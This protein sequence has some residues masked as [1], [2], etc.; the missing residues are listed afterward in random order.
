MRIRCITLIAILVFICSGTAF[1]ANVYVDGAKLD[2]RTSSENNTTL[3][4]LRS[5][6][7][8]LGAEV[9]WN[10][11]EQ[12]VTAVKGQTSVKLKIGVQTAFVNGNPV[13]LQVPGKVINGNT[14]VPLR[15]VSEALGSKVGWDGITGTITIT[16]NGNTQIDSTKPGASVKV[17]RVVDG[18]TIEVDLNGKVEK[19]RLIGVDTPETVH[20][21][22]GEEPYG[23]EASNFTKAQLTGKNV[24]LETDVQERDNYGRLLAY[25]WVDG[26][27]F[28]EVLVR[29]GYAQVATFP[30][31]IKYVDRFTAAQQQA[32]QGNKGLWGMTP[33]TVEQS[34]NTNQ[35]QSETPAVTFGQFVGSK[36]ST[37]YHEPNCRWAEKITPENRIMFRDAADAKAHGYEACK[38]CNPK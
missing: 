8:A 35:Q 11:A 10:G 15:F 16:S 29:E 12:T 26:K 38:V 14:M 13:N 2:V 25:I 20:P 1:A 34:Q 19:V 17:T 37:K 36:E 21:T 33:G 23:K 7:Q 5:I 18:D 27:M 6:F 24:S 31:N 22:K 30:P 32:R 3:V 9:T 4:P 28:N